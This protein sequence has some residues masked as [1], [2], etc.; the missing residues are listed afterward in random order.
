M[1]GQSV[2]SDH[3]RFEHLLSEGASVTQQSFE[4]VETAELVR[5]R[6]IEA[7]A[8]ALLIETQRA[9]GAPISADVWV[10][11]VAALSEM[12]P[13]RPA[14]DAPAAAAAASRVSSGRSS[15]GVSRGKSRAPT[16]DIDEA[17]QLAEDIDDIVD[18][19][20]GRAFDAAGD[21]LRDVQRKAKEV[22]ATIDRTGRVT[23]GQMQALVNWKLGV[24][25][26]QG[27]DWED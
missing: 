11:F 16:G 13:F 4:G 12:V 24:E 27:R 15:A 10:E 21:F 3:Y 5:L 9:N 23:P 19:L 2:S 17:L 8:R 1:L 26:W 6:R 20:P 22:V 14:P 7:T 18:N 25:R